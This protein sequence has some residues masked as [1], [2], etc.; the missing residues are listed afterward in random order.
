MCRLKKIKCLQPTP[1]AKCEACKVAKIPCKFRDRERY[2]AER[3][4]AIAGPG[5]A[6]SAYGSSSSSSEHRSDSSVD[7][8]SVASSSSSPALS[9]YS[10]SRSASH[11]PKASGLVAMDDNGSVRYSPY[12]SDTRRP[13][14]YPLRYPQHPSYTLMN[15]F[16]LLF[17]NNLQQ[18]FNFIAYDDVYREF[19]QRRM[20][21]S[22]ANCIAAHAANIDT[23]HALMLLAWYEYKANRISSF[24][25]YAQL[26]SRMSSQ[27]GYSNASTSGHDGERRKQTIKALYNLQYVASQYN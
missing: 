15:E 3:S 24:R 9:S 8:L 19:T 23:L 21:P 14:D 10:H 6:S 18:E 5:A 20:S 26:S 25:D 1:E 16:I 17:F 7:A 2:F 27:L 4:R 12:V 22:L 11:S 13:A